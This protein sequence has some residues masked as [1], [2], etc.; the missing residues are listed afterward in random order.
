[1]IRRQVDVIYFILNEQYRHDT[2]H[3]FAHM[4]QSIL[5]LNQQPNRRS[6]SDACECEVKSCL[7]FIHG[8]YI[9]PRLRTYMHHWG[10]P[11]VLQ[12]TIARRSCPPNDARGVETYSRVMRLHQH[13]R[14]TSQKFDS[15]DVSPHR[16]WWEW[17][18]GIWPKHRNGDA[19]AYVIRDQLDLLRLELVRTYPSFDSHCASNVDEIG[20]PPDNRYIEQNIRVDEYCM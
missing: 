4:M 18:R 6:L 11:E 13:I 8:A 10:V 14:E 5:V 7:E 15:A 3:R 16:G 20:S 2:H 17:L 9:N 19:Q 12:T 1:M